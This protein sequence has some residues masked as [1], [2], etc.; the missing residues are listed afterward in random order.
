M[1]KDIALRLAHKKPYERIEKEREKQIDLLIVVDQMLTGFDSKWINTLYLDKVLRYENIIQAFSRTNRLAGADKPFGTVKYYR[2]PNTMEQNIIKAVKLYSGDKPFGLFVERLEHNLTKLNEIYADITDLFNNAKITDFTKL[3]EDKTECGRFAKLFNQFVNHLEA[4]KIQSFSW[5]TSDYDFEEGHKKHT[6]HMN[7]DENTFITLVQRY[8][9]LSSK[10]NSPSEDI[11]YDIDTHISEIETDDIDTEYMNSRFDK[12]LKKLAQPNVTQDEMQSVLDELHKSF[13]SLTQDEQK[14][15]NIFLNDV[16]SGNVVMKEN[17]TL[18]DYITEYQTVA[19][20]DQVHKMSEAI[21][22][23]EKQLREFLNLFIN[24]N[25][26][27]EF[28]RFD[29]LKA[30]ADVVKAQQYFQKKDGIKYS[31][32]KTRMKIHQLLQDFILNGGFEL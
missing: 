19:K 7:L 10:T 13:A 12:Y 14:Y 8:K 3:P 23:D 25:N 32:A 28:G 30:T 15:A 27:N 1:K 21:G 31:P 22:I 20:N 17:K 11:P 4:A 26:I 29:S 24:E 9:E 18:R 5:N 2:Y 16:Q 6:I